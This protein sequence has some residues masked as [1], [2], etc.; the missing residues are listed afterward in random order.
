M[1]GD[2]DTVNTAKIT[3]DRADLVA[4]ACPVDVTKPYQVR[5]VINIWNQLLNKILDVTCM[6]RADCTYTHRPRVPMGPV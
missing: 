2:S 6:Q 1:I 3:C 4:E 5:S